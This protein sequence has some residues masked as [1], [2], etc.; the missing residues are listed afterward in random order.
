MIRASDYK[1]VINIMK[2]TSFGKILSNLEFNY[3]DE[4]PYKVAF[5]VCSH[6]IRFSSNPSVVMFCY[7]DLL[8]IELSNI[9]NIIEG[10]R[11]KMP[12]KKIV[13]FLIFNKV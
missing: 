13:K 4:V 12:A 2:A 6:Y 9:V 1:E 5:K 11:Y 7:V 8:N 10:I 3:P